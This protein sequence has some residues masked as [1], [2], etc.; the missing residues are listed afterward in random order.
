MYNYKQIRLRARSLKK[1][2][3]KK[4]K[5]LLLVLSVDQLNYLKAKF[6]DYKHVW[7][8]IKNEID[9]ENSKF[10]NQ[11]SNCINLL[12]SLLLEQKKIIE[13]LR[14][15]QSNIFNNLRGRSIEYNIEDI[16]LDDVMR[17]GSNRYVFPK[18]KSNTLEDKYS[19]PYSHK[20]YD[21]SY[22]SFAKL[23]AKN[24]VEQLIQIQ[25]EIHLKRDEIITLETNC[26]RKILELSKK[27]YMSISI[28]DGEKQKVINL[29]NLNL[30]NI[31]SAINLAEKREEKEAK[32]AAFDNKTRIL[33]SSIKR[34]LTNQ[35]NI[36]SKCPYCQNHIDIAT[37]H[38]DHIYPVSKGGLSVTKNMVF[39]CSS[40]NLAKG[41]LTLR[42]FLK[43]N[44][45]NEKVTY[46][47]L[48]RLSKE[49]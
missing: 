35:L 12:Q 46:E 20:S 47:I 31:D 40:C 22:R 48:E 2:I 15:H 6:I 49:F 24:Y 27:R 37:A 11:S 21:K 32:V 42:T 5:N 25:N 18:E 14:H 3:M 1:D 7:D 9:L 28:I 30:I 38:A 23:E 13:T 39:V 33:S 41:Q 17:V 8:K 26:Y 16:Y 10:K 45:F 29:Y 34:K 19:Y 4:D 36:Y 44:E 43:K